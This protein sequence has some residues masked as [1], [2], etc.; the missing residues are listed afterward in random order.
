MKDHIHAGFVETT[1]G[2]WK[3]LSCGRYF[4]QH[5]FVNLEYQI[6]DNRKVTYFPETGGTEE[7][8]LLNIQF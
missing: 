6:L 5:W 2:D 1:G 4:P 8:I 3:C 7:F